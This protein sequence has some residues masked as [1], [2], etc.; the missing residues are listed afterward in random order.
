[1]NGTSYTFRDKGTIMV[2]TE[3]RLKE[4]LRER[5]WT[6]KVLAG[7]TGM[8]E[9]YLTHIKNGTRR[10]NEDALD[11]ISRAFE[12]APTDL[13]AYKKARTD[14]TELRIAGTEALPAQKQLQVVP[15][16]G[17]LPSEPTPYANQ[18][19]QQETGYGKVFVPVFDSEDVGMFSYCVQD[20]TMA[21][22]FMQ[23]DFLLIS[24][25]KWT[26]SGDIAAVEYALGGNTVRSVAKIT[27][28]DEFIVLDAVNH[29]APPVAL[30]RGKDH[31]RVIGK[32]IYRYQNFA[33]N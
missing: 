23:G 21:P 25:E 14:A 5:R 4:L 16:L 6:T 15:V 20:M 26:R 29:K 31:F 2:S 30:V 9:S 3:L 32:V 22:M 17:R 12:I 27:Y 18:L 19:I 1:M 7:K 8:S 10:W 28:M 11:K 24:P 13:L 33:N